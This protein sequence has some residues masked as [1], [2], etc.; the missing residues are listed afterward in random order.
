MLPFSLTEPLAVVAEWDVAVRHQQIKRA[1]ARVLIQTP[2]TAILLEIVQSLEIGA[3]CGRALQKRI[4]DCYQ[5]RYED[6]HG[7]RRGAQLSKAAQQERPE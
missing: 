6:G 4:N 5:V 3:R 1:Y 2:P 7:A